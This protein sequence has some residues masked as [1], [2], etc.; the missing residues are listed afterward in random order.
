M[1]GGQKYF[2]SNAMF[3]PIFIVVICGEIIVKML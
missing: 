3:G 1:F 2:W